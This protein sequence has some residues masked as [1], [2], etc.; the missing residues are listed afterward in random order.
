M[1]GSKEVQKLSKNMNKD[2]D[3]LLEHS[4]LFSLLIN[5][6]KHI[7]EI[8]ER[9]KIIKVCEQANTNQ[10]IQNNLAQIN[11]D[12][13]NNKIANYTDLL[14]Q[15]KKE[16]QYAASKKGKLRV[17]STSV[18]PCIPEKKEFVQLHEEV[19][20]LA[21]EINDDYQQIKRVI[22][23]L[24]EHSNAFKLKTSKD[25]LFDIYAA[26]KA[27]SYRNTIEENIAS[28]TPRKETMCQ[29]DDDYI[30]EGV[31]DFEKVSGLLDLAKR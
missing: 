31:I 14:E 10:P 15:F 18:L 5:D 9:L 3:E 8:Y 16:Q 30:P 19:I 6:V 11:L 24:Q 25:H 26:Y 13:L 1:E 17:A 7:K 12:Y 29:V 4:V 27:L 21:S 2:I 20:S 28:L 23:H 22:P